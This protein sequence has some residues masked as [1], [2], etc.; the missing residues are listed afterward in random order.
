[1]PAKTKLK[2]N[3]PFSKGKQANNSYIPNNNPMSGIF[4]HPGVGGFGGLG[5][6]QPLGAGNGANGGRVAP[7]S[8]PWELMYNNSYMLLSLLQTVLTYAYTIHGPLRKVVNL[9]VYDAFRGGIKIVTDEV[10]EEDKEELHREIKKLKLI[11]KIMDGMRW[12]RLYG[13]AGII[14]NTDQDYSK[15]FN[16]KAI[17][18]NSKLSFIVADRWQLQWKGN[19]GIQGAMMTYAPN[20]NF[21]VG[22]TNPYLPSIHP[23][24]VARIVGEEA[25]SIIRQRLSGWGMSCLEPIIRP[26]NLYFKEENALFEYIDEFKVDIWKIDG[27]N[28]QVLSKAAKGL[29]AMRIQ[30]ATFMKNFLNAIT[31]DAKDD[32]QQKQINL[33]GLAPIMEQ[34]RINMA[35]ACDMPLSKLFGLAASGFDSGESDLEVYNAMVEIERERAQLVL[36]QII[37]V[38]MM[39]VWGFVPDDWS[40]EWKKLRVLSDEQEQNIKNAKHTRNLSLYDRGLYTP[41]EFMEAEKDDDIVSI[42]TEVAKGAEPEPPAMSFMGDEETLET[43]SPKKPSEGRK[44]TKPKT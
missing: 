18:E 7:L 31:L 29:T 2:P 19:P 11:P 26:I 21:V 30:I 6:G 25:P 41:K 43:S 4:D 9:P 32:Y 15:P 34:I 22:E 20:G 39:K 42:D 1:M 10:N 27:F 36:D 40:I 8:E 24:R 14:V 5:G 13:G 38:M 12:N 35:C 44:P 37:P 3:N 28:A 33:S 16:L 23:S 17:N